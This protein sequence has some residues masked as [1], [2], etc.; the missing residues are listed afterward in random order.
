M[1]TNIKNLHINILRREKVSLKTNLKRAVE[2]G[3]T[4]VMIRLNGPQKT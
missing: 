2:A 4:V 1:S 3:I